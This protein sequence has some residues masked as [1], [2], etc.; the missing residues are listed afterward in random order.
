MI[1][2]G[3]LIA[4]GAAIVFIL[5]GAL[6]L[7]GAVNTT[8]QQ[9]MPGFIPDQASIGERLVTYASIWIPVLFVAGF[10]LLTGIQLLRVGIAMLT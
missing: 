9:L 4:I 8:R 1:I 10:C 2:L 5:I 7:F 6:T 3:M